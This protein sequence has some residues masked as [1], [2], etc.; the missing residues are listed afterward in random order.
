MM[1]FHHSLGS[2]ERAYIHVY[3]ADYGRRDRFTCTYQLPTD[4]LQTTDCWRP[5]SQV[6][7]RYNYNL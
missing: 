6:A 2:D 1:L 3:A 7:Q 4:K 5:T